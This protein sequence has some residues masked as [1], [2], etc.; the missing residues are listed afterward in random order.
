MAWAL[1]ALLAAALAAPRVELPSTGH[2]LDARSAGPPSS[3][4]PSDTGR[5]PRLLTVVLLE[6]E[7][8]PAV[9]VSGAES[10]TCDG[11]EMSPSAS[12][13]VRWTRGAV[14]VSPGPGVSHRCKNVL[15]KAAQPAPGGE[16]G[17]RA[18][19]RL[20][21]GPRVR[22]HEGT[23]RIQ[24]G[25][26][27]LRFLLQLPLEDYVASV[28][29]S[30]AGDAPP[31]AQAAQAVVTRTWAL[32]HAG[33]HGE[34]DACDLTHCQ[35]YRGE[36]AEE[37][38]RAARRTAGRV[39][40]SD[41]ALLPAFFHA[42]CGGHTASARDV[43][44]EA[45]PAGV[46]DVGPSGKAWCSEPGWGATLGRSR[47]ARALGL[48]DR[49]GV[50]VLRRSAD[51]RAAEVEAFGQRMAGPLFVARV[52][53]ALGYGT[54]RSARF[55]VE[56]DGAQMRFEGDGRGHGVGYCQAGGA[57]RARAGQGWEA[58][59]RAY[60]PDARAISPPP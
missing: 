60:F 24:A 19:L 32:A 46:P 1:A 49:G 23:L 10:V 7:A 53:R 28:V 33:R 5:A 20:R 55:R 14:E 39:L 30:E 51:G 58:L 48:Q 38:D 26:R 50:Q 34:A 3:Q 42:A 17:A 40:S 27:A 13:H 29:A 4:P 52:G 9:R 41:G 37:A 16:C 36:R 31:E 45:G 12:P 21:A 59:L 47:L 15:L 56:A 11:R 18:A 35:L 43:F 2:A 8:L 57:A 44:G 6:R 54:L 22:C 25:P